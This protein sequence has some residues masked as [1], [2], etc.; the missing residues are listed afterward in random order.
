MNEDLFILLISNDENKNAQ[1]YLDITPDVYACQLCEDWIGI[2]KDLEAHEAEH[3][4][5]N[6]H[7][8]N[9]K[10]YMS[11]RSDETFEKGPFNAHDKNS[12]PI[13]MCGVCY[14]KAYEYSKTWHYK[15]N[16]VRYK[17]SKIFGGK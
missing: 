5:E 16:L 8:C 10:V 11:K 3:P 9:R 2:E 12:K 4:T 1:R 7:F 15:V 14:H 6:C 17:L 13:S